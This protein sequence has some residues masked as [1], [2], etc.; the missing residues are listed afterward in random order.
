[1]DKDIG[2]RYTSNRRILQKLSVLVEK[3]PDIRFN[4]LLQDVKVVLPNTD[5]FYEESIETLNRLTPLFYKYK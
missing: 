5:Q 1:M 4:Q 2:S 3:Y